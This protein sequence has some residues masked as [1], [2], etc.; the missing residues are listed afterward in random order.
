VDFEKDCDCVDHPCATFVAL[1]VGTT[2]LVSTVLEQHLATYHWNLEGWERDGKSYV[3]EEYLTTPLQQVIEPYT[4]GALTDLEMDF[5]APDRVALHGR[6]R[7]RPIS[8]A[9]GVYTD[10]GIP[11]LQLRQYDGFP[12]YIIGGILSDGINRGL[13][14]SW[15][16]VP[17]RLSSVCFPGRK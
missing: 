9:I 3:L 15:Q 16:E 2:F 7:E 8:L 14:T 6:F 1:L 11:Q 17:V 4:L 5:Y 12:L 10:G 13:T